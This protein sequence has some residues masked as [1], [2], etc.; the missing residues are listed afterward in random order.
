MVALDT[1]GKMGW[2]IPSESSRVNLRN[3]AAAIGKLAAETNM[4]CAAVDAIGGSEPNP[5]IFETIKSKFK[6]DEGWDF[7]V[8]EEMLYGAE[9]TFNQNIGNCVG[10]SH[11]ML[12]SARSAHEIVAKG[13]PE[14]PLGLKNL[15]IP[16]VPFSYGVGR[17]VG[18][19]LGPG[20]GSYCGAQMEGTL[21]YGFLPCNTE[22]LS[23]AYSD[24]PQG[25]SSVGRLFGKS[26]S[27]IQKWTDKASKFTMA[28]AP[29]VRD[30]EDAK[31]LVTQK[32]TPL[33]ICSGWGFRFSHFDSKYGINI[34]KP[35][36]SWS[37]SM[38][39]IA[40]FAIKGAWFVVVRNQWGK[41]HKDGMT[42]TIT[43]DDFARWLKSA[44][45]LGIGELKTAEANP[46]F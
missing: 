26:K 19:M 33:Q 30:V 5:K 9:L 21:K 37:H 4:V 24:L 39:I 38:Q 23:E 27:E 29:K 17:W 22:G 8:A 1:P 36:G 31:V 32:Y 34:Y 20:D 11:G 18:G 15:A 35:G 40:I 3:E 12:L 45:C 25:T 10:A 6:F 16:F 7:R 41:T 28:E 44:E 13:D 2:G 14:E 42:F 46:G 43:I